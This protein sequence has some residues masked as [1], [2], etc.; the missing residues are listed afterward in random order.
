MLT[1]IVNTEEDEVERMY[2]ETKELIIPVLRTIPIESSIH[3]LHL[4]VSI[5]FCLYWV[6]QIIITFFCCMCFRMYLNRVFGSRVKTATRV[7]PP[8][9]T[10]SLRTLP[11]SKNWE[12]CPN[13]IAMKASCAIYLR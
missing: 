1:N 11:N 3:R 4:T 2:T 12:G 13:Q 6:I 7:C 10:R 5:F 8:Q 9:S